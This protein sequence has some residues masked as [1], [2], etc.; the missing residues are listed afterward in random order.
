MKEK[1][2]KFGQDDWR[3]SKSS[4]FDWLF[5]D[6]DPRKAFEVYYVYAN[7]SE[8]NISSVLKRIHVMPLEKRKIFI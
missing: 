7:M 2:N 8:T 3:Q 6:N 4:I 1:L 5:Y